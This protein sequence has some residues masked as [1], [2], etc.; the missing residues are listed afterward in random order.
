MADRPTVKTKRVGRDKLQKFLPSHE[1]VKWAEGL[2]EDVVVTLPDAIDESTNSSGTVLATRLFGQREPLIPQTLLQAN[3]ADRV[4]TN[5]AFGQRQA[6]MPQT[7]AD[8]S[9]ILAGQVFG[10]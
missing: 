5:T 3:D 9:R 2:T 6:Q 8:S 4:M 7:D 1:L 10:G